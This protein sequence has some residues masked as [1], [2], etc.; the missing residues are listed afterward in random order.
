MS[1]L[2]PLAQIDC[3]VII[4]DRDENIP[5]YLPNRIESSDTLDLLNELEAILSRLN[6]DG[7][8]E[9]SVDSI[10]TENPLHAAFLHIGR[11]YKWLHL[12]SSEKDQNI[13]KAAGVKLKHFSQEKISPSDFE[14]LSSRILNYSS[15]IGFPFARVSL[16]S[17]AVKN[18]TEISA[19]L[20]LD[21]YK[22]IRY[23]SIRMAGSGKVGNAFMQDYLKLKTGGLYREFD[24][25]KI[26]ER[27]GNLN[28][29]SLKDKPR[30]YFY[31]DQTIID[32]NLEDLPVN[33]FDGIIGVFPNSSNNGKLKLTGDLNLLLINGFKKGEELKFNWKSIQAGT[34]NLKVKFA[35]PYLLRSSFGLNTNFHLFYR[36]SAFLELIFTAGIDYLMDGRNSI[37]AF[38]QQRN[39]NLLQANPDSLRNQANIESNFYGLKLSLLKLDEAIA[40]KKGYTLEMELAVGDKSTSVEREEK[41]EPTGSTQY[42]VRFNASLFIQEG[43]NLSTKLVLESSSLFNEKFYT[44]EVL[45]FGGF[46]S[47]MGFDEESLLAT[48]FASIMLEQRYFFERRSYFSLF[49]NSAWYENRSLVEVENNLPFGFGGGLNFNLQSG[50]FSLYYALGKN[51]DL[52]LQFRSAKIHFGYTY[53]L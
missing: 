35:Y 12:K 8:L 49:V 20:A 18:E 27:I 40:P 36:D 19:T 16:D 48:S 2:Q 13:L 30:I 41:S 47:L 7:Y 3:K 4:T 21:L 29:V 33:Q 24:I 53:F 46:N 1:S 31:N 38:Y 9:S 5:A 42:K 45:R 37:Q 25:Q 22:A 14:A 51:R 39:Y 17:L 32:L 23:D 52:S 6:N 34:Q 11:Q 28:F 50:I 15:N 44:N 43:K 26:E 10:K